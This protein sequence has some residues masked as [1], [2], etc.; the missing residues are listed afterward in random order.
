MFYDIM[1]SIATFHNWSYIEASNSTLAYILAK[2]IGYT[3][4]VGLDTV[5]LKLL[6]TCLASL[7]H[8]TYVHAELWNTLSNNGGTGHEYSKTNRPAIW[9]VTKEL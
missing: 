7:I 2:A 3:A 5:A 4:R 1:I 8:L 6:F 9:T